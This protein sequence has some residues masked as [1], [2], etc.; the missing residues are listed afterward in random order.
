MAHLRTIGACLATCL[1]LSAAAA[2]SP[3]AATP[4]HVGQD[5]PSVTV[6][7]PPPPDP[8]GD[9]DP[10]RPRPEIEPLASVVRSI[11]FPV[12]GS[13]NYTDT[14]GACRDGCTRF[15]E[16]IDIFAPKLR[17]LLAA[18][19]G[20]VTWLRT[21]ASGTAG[22]GIGITD[23]QG[24]RYLY[25]HVNNDSPGTDDGRNPAA[26]R[27]APGIG[28]GTKV[29]TGQVIGYLGDSGNAETTPSHLHFEIRTPDGVD[30]NPYNSLRYAHHN[31]PGPRIFRWNTNHAPPPDDHMLFGQATS[32]RMLAC[33]RNGDGHDEPVERSGATFRFAASLADPRIVG[34]LTWGQS[35]DKVICGDWDGNGTD[36]PGAI[37][38]NRFLLIDHWRGGRAT[39]DYYWG[40]GSDKPL[41]GDWNGDGRD[42]VGVFREGLWILASG[43]S[44][45]APTRMFAYG[46]ATDIPLTGDWEGDGTDTIGVRRGLTNYVRRSPGGGPA[47][48]VWTMGTS[49]DHTFTA[50]WG[51]ASNP[52][53]T[54]VNIWR[55]FPAGG[56]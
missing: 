19:D 18:R 9:I 15:H 5:G 56:G 12:A 20:Y 43:N 49:G 46:G 44:R 28:M 52:R 25:L 3:A 32:S 2:H 31:R 22:N 37:R 55:R 4:S 51:L 6:P 30:I 35:G 7:P 23:A 24:W 13:V 11:R 42:T 26:W 34:T 1:A 27:F 8:E 39:T 48:V 14:F 33:D 10:Y 41:A 36:T 21:D 17:H 29:Y 50:T 54:S 47:E 45:A 38:G 53:R 40:R 16:G